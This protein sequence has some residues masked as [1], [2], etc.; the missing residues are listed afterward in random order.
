V[1]AALSRVVLT[2]S[3]WRGGVNISADESVILPEVFRG[4]P[5]SLQANFGIV[6]PKLSSIAR[7]YGLDD[8]W[9][10]SRQR[11][12]IF[13]FTTVSRSTLGPTRPPIQWVS[14][15]ISLG[16]KR[17]GREA[18]YSPPCSVVMAWC[19]VK[20]QGWAY[21]YLGKIIILI[22]FISKW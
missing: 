18:D 15:A 21:P 9:F 2:V 11:L 19:S 17:P 6:L 13:L 8:G 16:V 1:F 22:I 12:G 5:Q 3:L 10:E 4:L 14:R 7:G 20:T